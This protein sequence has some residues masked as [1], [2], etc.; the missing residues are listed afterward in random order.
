MPVLNSKEDFNRFIIEKLLKERKQATPINKMA[1]LSN[2]RQRVGKRL[3]IG[4]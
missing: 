4:K 1:L 2:I 3:I